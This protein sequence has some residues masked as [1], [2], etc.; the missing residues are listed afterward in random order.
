M[1]EQLDAILA[2]LATLLGPVDGAPVALTGGIT[3][4]NYRVRFGNVDAVVRLCGKH[5]A[6]LGIDRGTEAVATARA[7]SLGIGPEVLARL[8]DDDVLVCSFLPGGPVA[9]DT[10]LEPLARAIRA[11]HGSGPLPTAFNVFSLIECAPVDIELRATA[12]RIAAAVRADGLV[13]CHNDLLA[14]NVLSDPSIGV[15]IV[16]WEYAGMNHRCFDLG[17][18]AANNCLDEAATERLLAAYFTHGVTDRDR[19]LVALMQFVSDLREA[20]WGTTQRDLSELDFDYAAYVRTHFERLR[21]RAADPRLED[22][23]ACAA[24]ST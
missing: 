8:A 7:A 12:R 9:I 6:A 10:V 23:I 11:F 2:R 18:L 16:D 13:S 24:A 19:A 17:N 5:T 15:R 21:A 1:N 22:W 14:A 20:V 3:N 4:R